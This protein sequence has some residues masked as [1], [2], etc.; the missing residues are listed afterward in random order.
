MSLAAPSLASM[1][2]LRI[3]DAGKRF[4]QARL[5][6]IYRHSVASSS[7]LMN[8]RLCATRAE[9]SGTPYL[10]PFTYKLVL[11]DRSSPAGPPCAVCCQASE[12][13]LSTCV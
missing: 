3:A 1:P 6:F 13:I 4:V 5:G 8:G 2:L 11:L 10:L 12:L 9:T 7:L